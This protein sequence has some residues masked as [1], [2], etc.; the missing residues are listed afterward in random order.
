M[1]G[2]HFYCLWDHK[3]ARFCRYCWLCVLFC[4]KD[5]EC[6]R[7]FEQC[8]RRNG[9]Q[10][11]LVR[12]V[13]YETIITIFSSASKSFRLSVRPINFSRDIRDETVS[14]CL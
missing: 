9:I 4:V 13:Q 10:S 8:L 3:N 7:A 12:Q 2:N 11:Q 1:D 14:V 6:Q 5:Q